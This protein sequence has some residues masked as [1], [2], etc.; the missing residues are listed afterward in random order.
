MRMGRREK[1]AMLGESVGSSDDGRMVGH[2][3][4]CKIGK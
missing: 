2:Q 4:M 1:T 3:G